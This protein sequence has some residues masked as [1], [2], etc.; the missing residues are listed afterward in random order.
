MTTN[1]FTTNIAV[2]IEEEMF[3]SCETPTDNDRKATTPDTCVSKIVRRFCTLPKNVRN[4]IGAI[5]FMTCVVSI[6]AIAGI[7]NVHV[8]LMCFAYIIITCIA[9]LCGCLVATKYSDTTE[10]TTP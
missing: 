1:D 5:W 8:A 2:N 3:Y 4:T 6:L 7:N 9:A 10:K